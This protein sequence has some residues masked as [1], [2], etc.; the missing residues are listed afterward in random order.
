MAW[1]K[2]FRPDDKEA[3]RDLVGGLTLV[4][5][6]TFFLTLERMIRAEAHAV[7][8]PT[9]LFAVREI[10]SG[11]SYFEQAT[12]SAKQSSTPAF[13]DATGRGADIGSE[14]HVA[15]ILRQIAKS[16][17]ANIIS[18]PNVPEMR[19]RKCRSIVVVDDL[20]GSGNRTNRFL[21][22][23]WLDR[24]IRSW[25]SLHYVRFTVIAFAGTEGGVKVIR[26][27][28]CAPSVLFDRECPTFRTLPWPRW[29]RE[30]AIR[31]CESYSSKTSKPNMKFGYGG[32]LASLVFEHGCPNNTPAILWATKAKGSQWQPLFKNRAVMEDTQTVFPREIARR[33]PVSVLVDAGQKRLAMTGLEQ[34]GDAE[35][36][37]NIVLLALIAKGI[38]R[39]GALT[40]GTG[41]SNADLEEKLR[42]CIGWGLVTPTRRITDA[43]LAELK[44]AR[45]T[46]RPRRTPSHIQRRE[47]YPQTLREAAH[48]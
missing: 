3:A 17:A 25:W 34:I 26:R 46:L 2:E 21:D 15:S 44:H 29:R 35:S 28:K 42:H 36:R 22:S 11:R 43:G 31:L 48:G 32:A 4:S 39:N 23:L 12:R 38:R 10:D 8:G 40:F 27:A 30:R 45:G 47:Y 33:D 13:T 20:I 9:A 41:L 1:L 14:G 5:F 37:E 24:T 18:H 6:S 19:R 7:S 16:D